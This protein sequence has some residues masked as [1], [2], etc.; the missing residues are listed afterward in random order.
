M[1]DNRFAL[2]GW[3][4]PCI[5]MN[6]PRVYTCPL[7]PEPP[8]HRTPHP[9]PLGCHRAPGSDSLRHAANPR[10]LPGVHMVMH[11][12][13]RCCLSPSNPLLPSLCP[14]V[15]S[16]C[17]SLHCCPACR[18]IST[19]WSVQVSERRVAGRTMLGH[20]RETQGWLTLIHLAKP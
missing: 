20:P 12:F 2:M 13:Q 11:L 5:N 15:S 19:I 17:P 14:H 3:F 6:Q 16:P 8:S 4:L 9:T 18:F 10:W 1:E 7:P